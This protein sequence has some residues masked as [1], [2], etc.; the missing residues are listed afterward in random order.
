MLSVTK[1]NRNFTFAPQAGTSAS[2]EKTETGMF[3]VIKAALKAKGIPKQA[4][5]LM[6]VVYQKTIQ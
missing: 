4:R 6:E 1:D 5:D 2:Y 3:S